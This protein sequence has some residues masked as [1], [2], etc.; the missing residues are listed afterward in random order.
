MWMKKLTCVVASLL[1]F[2]LSACGEAEIIVPET[3]RVVSTQP[4][5]GAMNILPT[6][7]V[8]IVFSAPIN[9]EEVTGDFFAIKEPSGVG[10]TTH[11]SDDNKT[12]TIK[13]SSSFSEDTMYIIQIKA[14]ISSSEE[15]IK[16]LPAP[17][18]FRF[19]TAK[20]N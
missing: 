14:D 15:N 9:H 6:E 13:P 19:R 11:Y 1:A 16:P 7:P 2:A 10:I 18:E 12:V 5:N 3:L 8:T 4:S 17:V 20:L